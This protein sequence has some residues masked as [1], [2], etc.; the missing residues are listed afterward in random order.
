MTKSISNTKKR[1]ALD[2]INDQIEYSERLGEMIDVYYTIRTA[3]QST[4]EPIERLNASLKNISD[5]SYE[6]EQGKWALLSNDKYQLRTILDAARR[7]YELT[8]D[9]P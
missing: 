7:Y 4:P 2:W 6:N 1:I 9:G 3:L 8:E 5:P